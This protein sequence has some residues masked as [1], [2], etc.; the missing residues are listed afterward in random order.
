MAIS[1]QLIDNVT[2][3]LR[4][5]PWDE[6]LIE[7]REGWRDMAIRYNRFNEVLGDILQ[8]VRGLLCIAFSPFLFLAS[9]VALLALPVKFASPPWREAPLELFWWGILLVIRGSVQCVTAPFKILSKSILACFSENIESQKKREIIT[10]AACLRVAMIEVEKDA[11]ILR[12]FQE[13]GNQDVKAE[14]ATWVEISYYKTEDSLYSYEGIVS[15]FK[16]LNNQ[17]ARLEQLIHLST[18]LTH[19]FAFRFRKSALPPDH[20][21]TRICEYGT[22]TKTSEKINSLLDA[23]MPYTDTFLENKCFPSSEVHWRGMHIYLDVILPRSDARQKT[24]EEMLLERAKKEG[25]KSANFLPEIFNIV[26]EYGNEYSEGEEPMKPV[27]TKISRKINPL[28]AQAESSLP[29]RN[30]I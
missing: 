19:S 7:G 28:V 22:N 13:Q 9:I 10:T 23:L 18:T 3:S 4:Y 26:A 25:E 8:P 27:P 11:K 6:L 5:E 1:S 24:I 2:N 21:C 29:Q 14:S 30:R 16:E 12:A 17:L 15:H 20:K